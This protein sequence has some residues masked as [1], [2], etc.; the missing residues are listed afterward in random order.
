[1][2]RNRER[3]I[4]GE[5]LVEHRNLVGASPWDWDQHQHPAAVIGIRIAATVR[6]KRPYV[7]HSRRS[8]LGSYLNAPET[9]HAALFA[10]V[11]YWHRLAAHRLNDPSARIIGQLWPCID[12]FD[13]IWEVGTTRSTTASGTIAQIAVFIAVN[14]CFFR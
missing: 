5:L 2:K 1:M 11:I 9:R 12:D 6:H 10:S 7:A 14:T 8:V 13:Q 4:G 3:A